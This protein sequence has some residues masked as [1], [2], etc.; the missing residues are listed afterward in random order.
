MSDARRRSSRPGFTLIELLV[1]IAIIAVLIGLLLPAVQAAREAARRAQCVNNLKQ[2]GLALHNYHDTNWARSPSGGSTRPPASAG[3]VATNKLEL[4]GPDPPLHGGEQ[5]LQRHQLQRGHHRQL[6]AGQGNDRAAGFTAW[7]TVPN[8]WLCPSDPDNGN[9]F[10]PRLYGPGGLENPWGN[11][12]PGLPPI[13]PATGQP[14]T[15][16]PVSNYAGS[17]GD[18]YVGGPLAAARPP[19]GDPGRHE[20]AAGPAPD[21]L[22][23]LLGHELCR[24]FRLGGGSLRGFF[25]YETRAGRD[26]RQRH[27][28]HQQHDPRRRGP[29]HPGGRQQLLAQE[30]GHRGHDRPDQLELQL[31]PGRGSALHGQLAGAAPLGCR[32]SAAAKGFKS[33]HPGGANFLF[34]DGSVKFLKQSINLATYCALGSRNGGEV[35]TADAY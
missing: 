33:K 27:R 2:I 21:R 15:I 23:R 3:P 34:A 14:H 4:A 16:V 31:L 25:D 11:A 17:F 28:R 6:D 7:V 22:Q 26:H 24:R 20:P 5:R 12:P 13:N 1:V 19:L 8:S 18:N 10:R 32:W 35:I 30:R 29:A 9:G